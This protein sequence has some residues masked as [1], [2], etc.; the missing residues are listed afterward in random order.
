MYAAADFLVMPS[1]FEPCG[2]NQ[3]IA[4]AYGAVPVVS[5][6]GGLVDTVKKYESFNPESRSGFGVLISAP[7]S[8]SLLSAVKKSCELYGNKK[9]FEAISDHNMK[10]DFSWSESAKAYIKLYARLMK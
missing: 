7:T 1:L 3:M 6:V 10:C 9:H 4:F 5:R 2:L 8:R